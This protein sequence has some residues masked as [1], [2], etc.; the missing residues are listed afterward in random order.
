METAAVKH[1][2][3]SVTEFHCLICGTH[4]TS[5]ELCKVCERR[6]LSPQEYAEFFWEEA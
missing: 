2:A 6:G 4:L 1:P 5:G 3:H